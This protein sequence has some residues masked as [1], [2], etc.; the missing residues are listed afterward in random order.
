MS[1]RYWA[2]I[3]AAGSGRRMGGECPKQY[4]QIQQKT[5]LDWT[6]SRLL[7]TGLF[8]GIAVALAEQDGDW[9]NSLFAGHSQILCCIGGAERS[10]SVRNALA[11]LLSQADPQDWVLVHDAA[12]PCVR[13]GDIQQLVA[14]VQNGHAGGLLGAPSIDSLK[15]VTAQNL[16]CEILDRSHIW[17]AFTPQMFRLG[18]LHE[19]LLLVQAEH[20]AVTDEASAM[21]CVGVAAVM[22]QGRGD[23]I[24]ITHPEDLALASRILTEQM[25]TGGV[26]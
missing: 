18:G 4:L 6:I 26:L 10:D 1:E 20:L 25:A 15:K 23:N 12:R 16:V 14:V 11:M 22:V 7:Q 24:K 17:R 9:P 3:P 8:S 2:V 13:V 19:A 5:I 21:A